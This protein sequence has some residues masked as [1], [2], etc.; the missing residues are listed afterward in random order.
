MLVYNIT[1]QTLSTSLYSSIFLFPVWFSNFFFELEFLTLKLYLSII[2]TFI[3]IFFYNQGTFNGQALRTFH[4]DPNLGVPTVPQQPPLGKFRV[5]SMARFELRTMCH[6]LRPCFLE[7]ALT[8]YATI[9]SYFTY[10]IPFIFFFTFYIYLFLLCYYM[11]LKILNEISPIPTRMP[12]GP[13]FL[14]LGILILSG[15]KWDLF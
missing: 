7:F 10:E 1:L 14:I 13:I 4:G 12:L 6:L 11:R 15:F 3:L 2:L 5:S 9:T 8:Y